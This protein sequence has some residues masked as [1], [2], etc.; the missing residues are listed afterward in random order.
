MLLL[1]IIVA[2]LDHE[3]DYIVIIINCFRRS[4]PTQINPQTILCPHSHFLK[5]PHSLTFIPT[6]SPMLKCLPL[7]ENGEG[8]FSV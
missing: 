3:I 7:K 6:P 5:R 1:S 4:K 2:I 8:G